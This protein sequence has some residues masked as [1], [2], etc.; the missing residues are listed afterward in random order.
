[1]TK[2]IIRIVATVYTTMLVGIPVGSIIY[3]AVRPGFHEFYSQLSTPDAVH[4]LVLT[5]EVTMLAVIANTIFGLGVALLLARHRFPGASFV[6]ALV[7]LPLSL[8]PVVIGLALTLCYSST[9][10]LL[11]PF[12]LQH[13]I[14]ILFSFPSIVMACAFVSL[15][16]VVREVQPL[17]IE[18]GTD[19]EQAAETLGAGPFVV[20]WKITMPSIRWGLAYGVL[21]TT[22]RVL[23][24]FG[25]V[26]V[27]SGNVTD[28]TQTMTL[29][30]DSALTNF[31]DAGA[32]DG[33]LLLA[34]I[35]MLV[36]V[37][38]SLSRSKEGRIR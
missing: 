36:L 25:A 37:A 20:F 32:Y 27:V 16:Y 19:Q 8:S 7:D 31:N 34:A 6:E 33:A 4:A 22:A 29:W 15:P 30:V 18:I 24:E 35:S 28:R 23:G 1:M 12:L 9:E 2:W 26:A 21:L 10:G 11:G 13:G 5:I 38:L 14:R 3:R 17:L